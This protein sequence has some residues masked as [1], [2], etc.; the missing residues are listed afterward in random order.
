M[1][2][3]SFV[4]STTTESTTAST[5]AEVVKPEKKKSPRPIGGMIKGKWSGLDHWKCSRCG[6]T[7]LDANEA[8]THTCKGRVVKKYEGDE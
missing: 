5:E 3:K 7:T 4:R 8:K 1:A 6:S 2:R